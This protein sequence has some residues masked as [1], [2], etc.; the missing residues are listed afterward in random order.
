MLAEIFKKHIFSVFRVAYDNSLKRVV[1]VSNSFSSHDIADYCKLYLLNHYVILVQCRYF[2][3]IMRMNN[4]LIR[5]CQ[6]FL[7]GGFHLVSLYTFLK[8]KYCFDFRFNELDVIQARIAWVQ[9]NE[10]RTGIR[11]GT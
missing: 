4:P 6:P 10:E 8:D 5:L 9:R 11:F 1:G 7:M 3:R 2:K